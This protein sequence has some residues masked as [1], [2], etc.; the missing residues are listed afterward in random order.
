[1]IYMITG[2]N[3]PQIQAFSRKELQ[4]LAGVLPK[5]LT[6]RVN[7]GEESRYFDFTEDFKWFLDEVGARV[8]WVDVNKQ[9]PNHPVWKT[10]WENEQYIFPAPNIWTDFRGWLRFNFQKADYFRDLAKEHLA[11]AG[12]IAPDIYNLPLQVNQNV[13]YK[14]YAMEFLASPLSFDVD[15]HVFGDDPTQFRNNLKWYKANTNRKIHLLEFRGT[16]NK[17]KG[18]VDSISNEAQKARHDLLLTIAVQELGDQLGEVCYFCLAANR[19][20]LR[21]KNP[22]YLHRYEVV[23]NVVVDRLNGMF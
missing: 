1:M 3:T 11:L 19:A 10:E 17:P 9:E 6:M 22:S 4:L 8:I 18:L 12:Y 20:A 23:N 16:P 5:G 7:G 14:A 15:L 13:G 2:Y 21:W